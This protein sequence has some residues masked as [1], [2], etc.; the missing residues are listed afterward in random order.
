MSEQNNAG[1][2]PPA[3]PPPAYGAPMPPMAPIGSEFAAPGAPVGPAPKP[4]ATAAMLLLV[5]AALGVIGVVVLWASKSSLRDAIAKKN[6]SFD[7]DKLNTAVNAA[8]IAASVFAVIF[9]VLFVWLSRQLTKGKNWARI[10][11]WILAGLGVISALTSLANPNAAL[12][13]AFDLLGG[14]I[15]LS[16]LVLLLQKP[17]NDFFRRRS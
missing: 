10:V 15:D 6:P 7:A 13:R 4:V 12:T 9:V 14:V 1:G 3:P 8:A 17:S 11:T 16:I 2:H 5:S